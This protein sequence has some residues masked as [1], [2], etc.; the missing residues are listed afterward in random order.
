MSVFDIFIKLFNGRCTN[1]SRQP[2]SSNPIPPGRSQAPESLAGPGSTITLVPAAAGVQQWSGA[3]LRHTSNRPLRNSSKG[4]GGRIAQA[5][6]RSLWS[7]AGHWQWL[8]I[9]GRLPAVGPASV[10]WAG[11]RTMFRGG[12]GHPDLHRDC[13]RGLDRPRVLKWP[14]FGVSKPK[15][16]KCMRQCPDPGPASQG[17]QVGRQWLGFQ[18]SCR[19]M[20]II[21]SF[22]VYHRL[23]HRKVTLAS[24][25]NYFSP[26]LRWGSEALQ[27]IQIFNFHF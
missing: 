8:W 23:Y 24:H 1:P 16:A 21:N 12:H 27:Y 7:P 19:L 25:M 4:R 9:S 15:T 3:D 5:S 10:T 18:T 13:A 20:L 22:T 2:K 11:T 17:K 6:R 14:A 26:K